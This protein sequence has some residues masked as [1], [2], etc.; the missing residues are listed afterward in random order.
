MALALRSRNSSM[1]NTKFSELRRIQ[2][3]EVSCRDEVLVVAQGEDLRHLPRSGNNFSISKK[4]QKR[5]S[6]RVVSTSAQRHVTSRV[7]GPGV[8]ARAP[9]HRA[10]VTP[11]CQSM[12]NF[13]PYPQCGYARHVPPFECGFHTQMAEHV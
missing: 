3:S 9:G 2:D 4:R 7:Q 12:T 13:A 8:T 11:A 5:A 1:P 10:A 6:A